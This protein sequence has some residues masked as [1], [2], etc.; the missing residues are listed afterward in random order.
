L[1]QAYNSIPAAAATP[2]TLE[3][4]QQP[5]TGT[6]AGRQSLQ[7]QHKQEQQQQGQGCGMT[8]LVPV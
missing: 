2:A 8:P 6:A 5:A 4:L 3:G 7:K 1:Q